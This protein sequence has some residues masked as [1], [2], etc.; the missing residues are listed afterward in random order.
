MRARTIAISIVWSGCSLVYDPS[1]FQGGAA[2]AGRER[3]GAVD[4]GMDGGIVSLPDGGEPFDAGPFDAGPA[5]RVRIVNAIGDTLPSGTALSNINVALNGG[6]TRS[7]PFGCVEEYEAPQGMMG[8]SLDDGTPRMLPLESDQLVIIARDNTAA[9]TM[10]LFA[11][12]DVPPIPATSGHAL[13][14]ID[15]LRPVVPDGTV[16]ISTNVYTLNSAAIAYGEMAAPFDYPIGQQSTVALGYGAGFLGL[17]PTILA[18]FTSADPL[19]EN[20]FMV[21]TG[22]AALHPSAPGGPRAILVPARGGEC[23]TPVAADPV[24]ALANLTREGGGAGGLAVSGCAIDTGFGEVNVN[25]NNV[26]LAVPVLANLTRFSLSPG[27]TDACADPMA[28]IVSFATMG[29]ERGR[30][31]LLVVHGL[32]N[33]DPSMW[34]VTLIDEAVP[35]SL[36]EI[37]VTLAHLASISA[38]FAIEVRIEGTL[39]TTSLGLGPAPDFDATV[40][41]A[42]TIVRGEWAVRE[43]DIPTNVVGRYDPNLAFTNGPGGVFFVLVDEDIAAATRPHAAFIRASYSSNWIIDV[44]P[45]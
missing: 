41:P 8:I 23:H 1:Q 10:T 18:T 25:P 3:D 34:D 38:P 17:E 16:Y 40:R 29:L 9:R 6:P 28:R 42:S 12:D 19:D 5:F 24:F 22:D 27:A 4:A 33:R 31:Y 21:L 39:L 11:Y 14:Y 30:R 43:M 32:A 36:G 20:T 37:G 13:T 7:I 15:L 35:P 2:D 44:R 45:N 26:S